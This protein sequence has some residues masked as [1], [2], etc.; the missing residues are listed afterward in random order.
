MKWKIKKIIIDKKKEKK[1][2][3]LSI[4]FLLFLPTDIVFLYPLSE[5]DCTLVG[6]WLP[7]NGK[8]KKVYQTIL[9]FCTLGH[10]Y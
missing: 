4:N 7:Q 9:G 1:R 6:T 8:K 5:H 10:I 2:K 3:R